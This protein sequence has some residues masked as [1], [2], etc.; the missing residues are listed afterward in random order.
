MFI[1]TVYRSC[2]LQV[3]PTALR[4]YPI[5]LAVD[6]RTLVHIAVGEGERALAVSDVVHVLAVIHKPANL[7]RDVTQGMHVLLL[8]IP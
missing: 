2:C 7:E 1:S 4:T 3:E 6:E 5:A 8:L